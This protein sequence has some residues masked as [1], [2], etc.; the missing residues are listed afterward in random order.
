MVT[1]PVCLAQDT[2]YL[3][4]PSLYAGSLGSPTGSDVLALTADLYLVAYN[5]G[6]NSG[7]TMKL[8]RVLE[9]SVISFVDS[10]EFAPP[11]GPG[12]ISMSKLSASSF[13]LSFILNERIY[14]RTG[15]VVDKALIILGEIRKM[16]SGPVSRFSQLAFAGNSFLIT[17]AD[18]ESESGRCALG[19]IGENLE[20]E[21]D[22]I[23]YFTDASIPDT[24]LIA[25]DTLSGSRAVLSYGAS[26]GTTR[27]VSLDEDRVLSFG[28]AHKF[29]SNQVHELH[30]LGLKEGLFALVYDDESEGKRRGTVNLGETDTSG[31]I[32]YSKKYFFEEDRPSGISAIKLLPHEFVISYNG[33]WNDWYGYLVRTRVVGDSVVFNHRAMFNP[34]PALNS[35]SPVARFDGQDFIVTYL[36]RNTYKGYARL[37]STIEFGRLSSLRENTPPAFSIYP[38]PTSGLLHIQWIGSEFIPEEISLRLIDISGRTVLSTKHSASQPTLDLSHLQKGLYLLQLSFGKKVETQKVVVQ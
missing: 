6:S 4:K 29:S 10:V 15:E 26:A 35:L 7:G 28:S 24:T 36:N 12:M 31:A 9:D 16:E 38:N 13:I 18:G 2:L 14:I 8:G 37:A 25:M 21:I 19:S 33:G 3:S 5:D 27:V 30:V 11:P 1:A 34:E 17:Y 22:S 20:I 23:Y 32:S